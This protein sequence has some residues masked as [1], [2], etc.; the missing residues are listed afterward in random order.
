MVSQKYQ[1]QSGYASHHQKLTLQYLTRQARST[2]FGKDHSFK[3]IKTSKDF[4]LQVPLRDYEGFKSYIQSMKDGKSNVLWPG[5]PKYLAKTSGTTSGVKYIPISVES[6]PFHIQCARDATLNMIA[7]T[8]MFTLLNDKVMFISGSPKVEIGSAGVK[9]GRLSGIVNHEIP[10][11]LKKNQLPDNQTNS[12]DDWNTKIDSIVQQT[13]SQNLRLIGGIP[14]WVQMYYEKLLDYT[15]KK[16]VKDVFPN[17]D[18]YVYGGV[19]FLPYRDILNSLVGEN[20]QS[21]ETY[22]ASE[23]FIA[24]QDLPTHEGLLLMTNVGIYYEFVPLSEINAADPPRLSLEHV[25]LDKDYA[26]ILSTNAGLWAYMIGDTVR[27]VNKNPYRIIVSGRTKQYISAFGEHVIAK[28]VEEALAETCTKHRCVVREFTVA[29]HMGSSLPYHQ[30]F[31]EFEQKP[32]SMTEFEVSLDNAMRNKNIYY[33]DLIKGKVLQK[34]KITTL[35]ADAFRNYMMSIGKLG[36]QNKVP[37]ISNDRK[38]A[39]QLSGFIE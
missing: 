5:R 32:Q 11:W 9:I 30:W 10:L 33:D 29:P 25:E 16:S 31:V 36:G 15:G 3:S 20:I 28:E 37:R 6:M 24:F 2:Q 39:D 12:I 34:L 13:A 4:S 22:P 19:N 35:H 8:E 7:H 26:I 1:T 38:I 23:G 18:L 21:L 14:P 17:L 27:F